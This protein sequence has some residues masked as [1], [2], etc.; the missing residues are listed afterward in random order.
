MQVAELVAVSYGNIHSQVALGVLKVH[1]DRLLAFD[2]FS[3]QL[4][5]PRRS[6][7]GEPPSLIATE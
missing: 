4:D 3:V 6:Q 7:Y 5:Y 2:R 1:S